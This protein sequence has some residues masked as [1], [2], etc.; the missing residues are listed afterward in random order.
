MN[1]LSVDNEFFLS[2]V[3]GVR[4]SDKKDIIEK[5]AIRNEFFVKLFSFSFHLSAFEVTFIKTSPRPL[6]IKSIH[7]QLKGYTQMTLFH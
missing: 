2:A 6:P 4:S 1:N 5:N 3:G 7:S